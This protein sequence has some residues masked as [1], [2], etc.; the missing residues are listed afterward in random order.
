MGCGPNENI[1]MGKLLPLIVRFFFFFHFNYFDDNRARFSGRRSIDAH[2]K[3]NMNECVMRANRIAENLCIWVTWA[4][5]T[6]DTADT[7]TQAASAAEQ[8]KILAVCVDKQN[9]KPPS[10]HQISL[11]IF[12]CNQKWTN[13]CVC[14]IL[15]ISMYS[16]FYRSFFFSVF[17]FC[18]HTG[19]WMPKMGSYE[20]YVYW[21]FFIWCS[22]T[23]P[24]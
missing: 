6:A 16:R 23:A 21:A 10:H 2:T 8:I 3:C 4:A 7:H 19:T 5:D 1:W 18:R 22:T 13:T 12:S 15:Y 17:F 14:N 20:V 9:S 24:E 11:V